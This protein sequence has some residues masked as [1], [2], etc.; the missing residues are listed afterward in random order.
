[1]LAPALGGI[2]GDRSRRHEFEGGGIGGNCGVH[3][4]SPIIASFI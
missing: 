4:I 2:E 1:V 3:D